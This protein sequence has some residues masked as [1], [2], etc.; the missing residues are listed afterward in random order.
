[1]RH[2]VS[3]RK[4]NR[5]SSHR[6]S[7][8]ENMSA[9]LLEHEQIKTTLPKAKDLRSVVEKI[10]T[11]GKKG[12]LNSRR[13]AFSK[14]RDNDIVKKLFDTLAKR[15]KDRKGGYTRIIKA[16]FRHGDN[17]PMAVIE[18]VD[19]DV[20]AKGMRQMADVAAKKVAA[21]PIDAPKDAPKSEAKE[22]K[23]SDK[24]SDK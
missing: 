22:P 17:S 8:F 16:G 9:S 6:K 18:L 3:K 12:D 14:L 21:K 19:R 24:K 11:F 20:K 7:M 4:L 10:I 13:I 5:T 15:Y 1:M 2:Q 23:K